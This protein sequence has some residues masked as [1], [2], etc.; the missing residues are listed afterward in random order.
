MDCE[1]RSKKEDMI[2]YNWNQWG[3]SS[4]ER[5]QQIEGGAGNPE[6]QGRPEA[7]NEEGMARPYPRQT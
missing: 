1:R 7:N 5:L 3:R 2:P 6:L 4:Q